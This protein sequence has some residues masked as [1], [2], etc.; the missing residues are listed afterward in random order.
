MWERTCLYKQK[1][2]IAS[3]SPTTSSLL[4][5]LKAL[6][7]QLRSFGLG[8]RAW[9]FRL[10]PVRTLRCG[11]FALLKEAVTLRTA[12]RDLAVPTLQ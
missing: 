7:L 8:E 6:V 11:P 9:H 4:S 1:H 2:I 12:L 5:I 10:D 3:T